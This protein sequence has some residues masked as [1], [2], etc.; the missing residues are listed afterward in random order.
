MSV[1]WYFVDIQRVPVHFVS[2]FIS[3]TNCERFPSLAN[4]IFSH[5]FPQSRVRSTSLAA[6][7]PRAFRPDLFWCPVGSCETFSFVES[8]RM[9]GDIESL[10][11][12]CKEICRYF[13]SLLPQHYQRQRLHWN[14]TRKN[15]NQNWDKSLLAKGRFF[16]LKCCLRFGFT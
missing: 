6:E 3:G 9:L 11:K 15:S 10:S 8:T 14:L 4:R 2:G 13:G 12:D 16:C 7:V 5:S 1:L